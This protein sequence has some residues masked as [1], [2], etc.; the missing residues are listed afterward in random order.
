M[1]EL[2]PVK[3]DSIQEQN[4]S[5]NRQS[6][7]KTS[8]SFIFIICPGTKF[9]YSINRLGFWGPSYTVIFSCLFKEKSTTFF[10]LRYFWY[11]VIIIS[12]TDNINIK[13]KKK[14]F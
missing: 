9:S 6:Q 1:D 11:V 2:S 14:K 5:S 8:S 13:I 4:P 3:L 10:L 12:I 7:G